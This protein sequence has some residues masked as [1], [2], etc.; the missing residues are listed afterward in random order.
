MRAVMR[1]VMGAV[2][3]VE[4]EVNRLTVIR[5]GYDIQAAIQADS[6]M[7]FLDIASVVPYLIYNPP[8]VLVCLSAIQA[9]AMMVWMMSRLMLMYLPPTIS[10][11]PDSWN[12]GLQSWYMSQHQASFRSC[13]QLVRIAFVCLRLAD[14]SL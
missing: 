1:A 7:I 4:I 5:H 8:M 3:R 12:S 2:M 11:H 14:S 9:V 10:A 6:L 13:D